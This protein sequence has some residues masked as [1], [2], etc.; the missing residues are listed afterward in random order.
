MNG[1][2]VHVCSQLGNPRR[3]HHHTPSASGQSEALHREHRGSGPGGQGAGPG[4]TQS[5][6]SFWWLW[7]SVILFCFF[8]VCLR[9][10][11]WSCRSDVLLCNPPFALLMPVNLQSWK[12][13]CFYSEYLFFLQRLYS[14]RTKRASW[15]RIWIEL[16]M[17]LRMLND[18]D[19]G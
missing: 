4:N 7:T 14:Q 11:W 17:P 10:L 2:C 16:T 18:V 9:L 8:E 13:L 1:V 6:F 19:F 5:F 3:L 12:L 15:V